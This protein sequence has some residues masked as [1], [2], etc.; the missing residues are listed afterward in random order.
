MKTAPVSA[1][2]FVWG[3]LAYFNAAEGLGP[4]NCEIWRAPRQRKAQQ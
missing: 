1:P 4:Q 3:S 2:F